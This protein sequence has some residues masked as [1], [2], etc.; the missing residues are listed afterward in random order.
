MNT[1]TCTHCKTSKPA[2]LE[3]FYSHQHNADGLESW[4]KD[5]KKALSKKQSK[6]NMGS[7]TKPR[8]AGEALALSYFLNQ[9]I[10]SEL[11]KNISGMS[12]VDLVLWGCV[13]VEVKYSQKPNYWQWTM[14]STNNPKTVFPDAIMLI[15]KHGKTQRN[16]YFIISPNHPFF[17]KEDNT[18]KVSLSYSYLNRIGKQG[19]AIDPLLQHENNY[20]LIEK[21]RLAHSQQLIQLAQA[22]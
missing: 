7:D 3:Y 17:I 12:W 1:R 21:L 15:G 13:K 6:A 20:G 10:P 9:G 14:Y 19:F 18:R 5:C 2:T 16:H 4:C 22:A 8:D 11:G